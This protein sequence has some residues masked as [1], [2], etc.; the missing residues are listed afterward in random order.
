MPELHWKHGYVMFWVLV[1]VLTVVVVLW[2]RVKGL[3][4]LE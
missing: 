1:A 4:L 2:F 3:W